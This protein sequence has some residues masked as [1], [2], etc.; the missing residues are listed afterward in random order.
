M[1]FPEHKI[2]AARLRDVDRLAER[3]FL[4][5]AVARAGDAAGVERNLHEAGAIEP[6]IGLA[7]PQIRDPEEAFGD[8]DEVLLAL[9]ERRDVA[10]RNEAERRDREAVLLRAITAMRLPSGGIATGGSLIEGP[11]NASVRSVMTLCVGASRGG[12]RAFAGSQ[13]T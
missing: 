5:V 3:G 6:E 12:I 8:R 7:A 10:E 11:G 2:A 4:H 13:P 9:R 1:A